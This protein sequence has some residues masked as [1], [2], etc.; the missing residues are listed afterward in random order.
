MTTRLLLLVFLAL[1][2]RLPGQVAELLGNGTF[3]ALAPATPGPDGLVSGWR[4]GDPPQLPGQWTLN[5]AYPGELACGHGNA[6]GGERYV[7]LSAPERTSAHLYQMCVGLAPDSWYRVT[8]WARGGSLALHFYE[9][10]HDGRIGGPTVAQ[11][12]A[13][14][15]VWRLVTGF[16]RT[17]GEGYLRSALA[18]M[19]PPGTVTDVDDVTL[20]LLA[21][22]ELPA[23]APDI[24]LETDLLRVRLSAA[25]MV[26]EFHCRALSKDYAV[27]GAPLRLLSA[28]HNGVTVPLH[29][30]SRDGDLLRAQFLDPEVRATLRV[31]PRRRH[32]LF[33][34][35]E[36]QPATVESLAIEFPVR[37]LKT[38]AWAFNG[39]YDDEFGVCF[40][41]TSVN[42]YNRP[43]A[44]GADVHGL[45]GGC[46]ARHG[47]LGAAF[48]LVAAPFGQ[49][50]EAIME[51]ER[52]NGL[53]CPLLEGAWARFSE[54]V[55]RSYLFMVDASEQSIDKTIEYA[56]LGGFGM[57]L[58]LKDNWLANH[59]HYEVNRRN[60]PEGRASLQRAVAKIHAAGLQAGV[61]VFG[62]S[63]SPNDPYITPVPD[64]RLAELPCPPLAE[65]VDETTTTLV[66]AAA[67]SLPER[68]PPT[69]PSPHQYLRLGDEIVRA[70][71]PEAGPPW[72]FVGCQRGAFGT[73][74]AAHA[75]GTAVRALL[76]VW[77]FFMVDPDSTLADEVTSQFADVFN[78]CDFDM[79]YFDASDG[80]R[81]AKC[82]PWYY[83]NAMHLKHYRKLKKDVIY[84]TS[85]GTG[86]N[87]T[88]HLVPRSASADGHGDLKGYLDQ[89]LPTMLG[90]A[91][92]FTRAD[93]GWY[94]LFREVRPDQI[95]YV[96]A[97][98]IG[99]DGSISI[100]SSVEALE[101]H[102]QGRQML[103]M[104]GR[105][106][107]CRLARVFP[108]PVR[109]KLREPQRDFKLFAD[110]QGGWQLYRAAY[111]E[112][113]FVDQLDGQQNVWTISNDQPFPCRLG[114][115]IVRAAKEAP[116]ADYNAAGGLTIEAFDDLT[117]YQRS[118]GNDFDR[119][120]IGADKV[121]TEGG[122]VRAGVSQRFTVT[123]EEAKV[124]PRCALF[125]AENAG[126][127]EAWG[128]VG[129]RF[130]AP[131]DL[132]GYQA[133]ALWIHGDGQG[134]RIRVQVWDR[135][136]RYANWL[137]AITYKGWRLH[138]FPLADA[139]D[140]D[141]ASVEYLLFYFNN[142]PAKATVQVKL[143]DLRALPALLPVL[144]LSQP[145]LTTGD[146]TRATYDVTLQP[147]QGLTDEGPGG[148]RF[149]PGRMAAPVPV[150]LA[151]QAL[152]LR[153]G[154]NTVTL[155][156]AT[157]PAGTQVLLYRLWPLE[158]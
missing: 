147:R 122:A 101:S 63:I 116:A 58:F 37:R 20:E 2:V 80:M 113:R 28:V 73:R 141:W 92:N 77:G 43:V 46:D 69:G 61:H 158:P 139:T 131:L 128:G 98:T 94:Y 105:Y 125:T 103:E 15:T 22:P 67:P 29:S 110:G 55:R 50:S 68:T 23:T 134:Q 136:G 4:L 39:T 76:T 127:P 85:N 74:P 11:S 108:E 53:P 114:V 120:V 25:G 38:V 145:C 27:A 79:V 104:V 31:V 133:L 59:G 13:A 24:V 5:P 71:E 153:P 16:Y 10:Y 138:V 45:G 150:A 154:A 88:W 155:S 156:A 7:R 30:L 21:V 100:E 34:V 142:I 82:A 129:R 124:G 106:E 118:E 1:A 60:F 111:E 49:F 95:E 83:L 119:F 97:K 32:L 18:L 146:G 3:E 151:G 65:A 107:Q 72:R 33:E 87:L 19:A 90:M 75:T 137:P 140:F 78:E 143:D 44:H 96:C 66:L 56:R 86:S 112:P 40:F 48:A 42:T 8:A 6:H 70:G 102:P 117:Q 149:W 130:A 81:A 123:D 89:R 51:A 152:E 126:G 36:V 52:E 12:A 157:F 54:P 144:P 84:Q 35:V 62:P 57:I 93:V 109:Q 64:D 41:G 135:A 148:A 14:G 115:E 17:P 9:Y 47:L 26:Q 132:S 99:I 121:V 91:A